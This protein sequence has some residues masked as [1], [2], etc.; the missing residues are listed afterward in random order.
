ME[1]IVNKAIALPKV[2]YKVEVLETL[3]KV[4]EVEL[5]LGCGI[6]ARQ[7]VMDMYYNDEIV[8]SADDYYETEFH[9][10]GGSEDNN[11]LNSKSNYGN[12][13]DIK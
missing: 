12:V 4:V 3:K 10:L 8:L 11:N 2:K 1:E 13:Q 6:D 7:K 5:P 9:F